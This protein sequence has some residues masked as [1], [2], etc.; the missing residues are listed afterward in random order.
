MKTFGISGRMFATVLAAVGA[1]AAGATPATAAPVRGDAGPQELWDRFPLVETQETPVPRV[2]AAAVQPRSGAL[3][4]TPRP[5]ERNGPRVTLLGIGV[6]LAAI[7][8][9][10]AGALLYAPSGPKGSG[11]ALLIRLGSSAGRLTATEAPALRRAADELRRVLRASAPNM[12]A[13]ERIGEWG[14]ESRRVEAVPPAAHDDDGDDQVPPSKSAGRTVPAS[15]K[16]VGR[17]DKERLASADVEALKLKDAAKRDEARI[18]RREADALKAKAAAP[19]QTPVLPLSEPAAVAEPSKVVRH[20][21]HRPGRGR[22]MIL[23]AQPERVAPPAPGG[24]ATEQ[25]RTCEIRLWHGYVKS[26]FYA[27]A[28]GESGETTI[29]ESSYFRRQKGKPPGS[30]AAAST[31]ESFVASLERDGWIVESREEERLA[32]LSPKAGD[33]TLLHDIRPKTRKEH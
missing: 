22:S 11:R 30:T 27:V 1:I 33:E 3:E 5:Q 4:P 31:R 18:A 23:S 2:R 6:A 26:R 9:L 13:D 17:H 12:R 24:M 15:A 29:A 10:L 16:P 32:E 14:R 25:R 8:F 20:S 7:S 19:P 21:R 28:Q